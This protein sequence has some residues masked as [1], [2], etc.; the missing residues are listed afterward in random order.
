MNMGRNIKN[1]RKSADAILKEF[2]KSLQVY[3]KS[4]SYREN[5]EADEK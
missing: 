4:I 3:Q 5:N 2:D 1:A